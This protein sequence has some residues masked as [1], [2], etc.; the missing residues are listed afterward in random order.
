MYALR[1]T[2]QMGDVFFVSQISW[3]IFRKLYK[4]KVLVF[5][6]QSGIFKGF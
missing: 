5:Q 4:I 6:K 1:P 2:V 3:H